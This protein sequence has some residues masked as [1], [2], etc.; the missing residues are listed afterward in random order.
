M[1]ATTAPPTTAPATTAPPTTTP[2]TT[3]PP[4]TAPPTTAPPTTAPTTAPATTV[5]PAGPV[6]VTVTPSVGAGSNQW[7]LAEQANVTLKSAVGSVQFEIHVKKTPGVAYTSGWSTLPGY[8]LGETTTDTEVVCTY[9]SL[10]GTVP[11]GT[12]T[13]TCGINMGTPHS[14]SADTWVLQTTAPNQTATGSMATT[15]APPPGSVTVK[16]IAGPDSNIWWL[17]EQANVTLPSAVGSLKFE[18]HIKLTPGIGYTGGWSTLPGGSQLVETTT[19]T[20]VVCSFFSPP[21]VL[22]AGTYTFTCGVNTGG[23]LHS[24]SADPW[25]L[26]TTVPSQSLNGLM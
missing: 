13:F 24:M 8:Q 26:S 5:P 23:N 7:W 15:T 10:P 16:P 6:G 21:G 1:V 3:V 11:A 18:I 20:E 22:S 25:V 12:Y 9:T 4:T 2:A 14:M 17:E 19:A